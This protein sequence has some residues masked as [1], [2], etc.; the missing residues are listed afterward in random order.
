MVACKHE[1]N[2]FIDRATL[3]LTYVE[4][5]IWAGNENMGQVYMNASKV[6]QLTIFK[7]ITE[8]I[9]LVIIFEIAIIFQLMM[10]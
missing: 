9:W 3:Y 4:L 6:V 5:N 2:C 7:I 1:L 10:F 8:N